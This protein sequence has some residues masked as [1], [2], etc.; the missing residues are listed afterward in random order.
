M[1]WERES[2]LFIYNAMS[3]LSPILRPFHKIS[4]S[5]ADLLAGGG[6]ALARRWLASPP[7]SS[8]SITE[9]YDP[10][11]HQDINSFMRLRL[12]LTIL[13]TLELETNAIRRFRLVSIVSYSRPSLMI[14]ASVSQFHV[15]L[16]WG[17]RPFSIVS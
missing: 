11:N 5:T 8:S 12:E 6:P 14:I 16:P 15:Y 3:P 10:E 7:L 9:I 17:Q 1:L 2:Y 4:V 13:S